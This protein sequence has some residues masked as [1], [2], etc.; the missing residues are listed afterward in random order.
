MSSNKRNKK[1]NK[2]NPIED[3]EDIRGK[4]TKRNKKK[5]RRH[6][7]KNYLKRFTDNED[8]D[9]DDFDSAHSSRYEVL[10]YWGYLDKNLS[11]QLG[12]EVPED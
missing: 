10:E 11:E 9:E 4:G 5:A 6:N 2:Y 12:L 3:M 1:S 8:Y 7:D